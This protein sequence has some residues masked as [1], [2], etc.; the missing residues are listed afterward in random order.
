MFLIVKVP[1]P[2]AKE[3][4]PGMA[5]R[6]TVEYFIL[7]TVDLMRLKNV[8]W[9]SGDQSWIDDLILDD[10]DDD[11]DDVEDDVHLKE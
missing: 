4:K 9:W 1:R 11:N 2:A 6:A 3:K 7:A 5:A 8:F 10:D